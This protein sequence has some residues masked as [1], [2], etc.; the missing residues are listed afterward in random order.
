LPIHG[1]D[2]L[3]LCT[4]SRFHF[5]AL[6]ARRDQLQE[7]LGLRVKPRYW[8]TPSG[9]AKDKVGEALSDLVPGFSFRSMRKTMNQWFIEAIEHDATDLQMGW[10]DELSKRLIGQRTETLVRLYR[11]M[12]KEDVRACEH[13]SGRAR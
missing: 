13:A 11:Q 6:F 12:G 10:V 7:W 1:L 9:H 2:F 3:E 4:I 5:R 8:N